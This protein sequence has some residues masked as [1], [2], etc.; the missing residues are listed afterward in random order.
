MKLKSVILIINKMIDIIFS[1]LSSKPSIYLYP[2]KFA[3]K[4]KIEIKEDFINVNGY[5]KFII[6]K[7]K[8]LPNG[9][10]YDLVNKYN[11]LKE[12]LIK[13]LSGKTFLDLGAN[14]GFF[15]FL[16]H[17]NGA[18]CT[19]IDM[20]N[21]Y[22]EIIKKI[23]SHYNYNIRIQQTNISKWNESADIVYA[24]SLIHWIYSCTSIYGSMSKLIKYLRSIT[25]E[26][27]IIEWIDPTD[28]AIKCFKHINYNKKLSNKSYNHGEFINQ[29]NNNFSK[30]NKIG[31]TRQKT[32]VIYKA[33]V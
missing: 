20:D 6:Y 18:T 31:I 8:I 3:P 29:L 25:N 15:T 2:N 32:R 23:T 10:S 11:L 21:E 24:L 12:D 5:Q 27:L 14:S 28:D 1:R 30:I 7:N 17:Q 33:I 9:D 4:S 22:I 13:K 26:Y 19:A 16:A